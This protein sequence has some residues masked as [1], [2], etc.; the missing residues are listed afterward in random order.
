MKIEFG[1]AA[2]PI[3]TGT[4]NSRE[5]DKSSLKTEAKFLNVGGMSVSLSMFTAF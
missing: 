3:L 5:E 2:S 1:K 4:L